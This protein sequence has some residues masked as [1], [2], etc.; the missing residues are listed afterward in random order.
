VGDL[1]VTT[2]VLERA[3]DAQLSEGTP[4]VQARTWLGVL[5]AAGVGL[6]VMYAIHRL[7][8]CARHGV[9]A[10]FALIEGR[11][12]LDWITGDALASALRATEEDQR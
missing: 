5:G 1:Y 4:P 7:D 9:R 10:P 2:G 3:D 11:P 8:R 6:Q 12:L